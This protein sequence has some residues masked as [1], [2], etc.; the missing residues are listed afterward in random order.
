MPRATALVLALTAACASPTFAHPPE[1]PALHALRA[2]PS[3]GDTTRYRAAL[4]TEDRTLRAGATSASVALHDAVEQI[5]GEL[6]QACTPRNPEGDGLH[7]VIACSTETI[8]ARGVSTPADAAV[9]EHWRAVGRIVGVLSRRSFAGA[10]RLRLAVSGFADHVELATR[11]VG[12]CAAQDFWGV[13][14]PGPTADDATI[15]RALSFCRAANMAREIGCAAVT[16]PCPDRG[17]IERAGLSVGVFGGGTALLDAHPD[18][19]HTHLAGEGGATLECTCHAI[20]PAL[21]GPTWNRTTR[22]VPT[23]AC[24][25]QPPP[26][27]PPVLYDCDSARRV[28][29]ALWLDVTPGTRPTNECTRRANDPDARALLCLQEATVGASH[30]NDL[31]EPLPRVPVDRCAGASADPAWI[32]ARVGAR[33]P[34]VAE[35]VP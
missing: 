3:L 16:G 13:A 19:Y 17:A 23:A 12:Q 26:D 11:D 1:G 32:E 10:P 15:N 7:W 6:G 24:P 14:R 2:P 35:V 30:H 34:C 25:A 22:G 33:P 21:L 20:A 9:T 28:E 4:E 18:R 31:R 27:A 5:V 29:L 8:F